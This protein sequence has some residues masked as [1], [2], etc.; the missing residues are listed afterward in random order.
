[1]AKPGL[2]LTNS[3]GMPKMV[4]G[5]ERRKQAVVLRI[6][7]ATYQQIG[8]RI[9]VNKQRAYQ[10]V[11][12]ALG[13]TKRLT[14]ESAEELKGIELERLDAL[15]TAMWP[16]AMKGDEQKVDR[17]L[18]IMKRRAELLGLDA[19]IRQEITTVEPAKFIEVERDDEPESGDGAAEVSSGPAP[20]VG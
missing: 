15:C 11:K 14:A 10:L 16:D 2:P 4:R 18:R 19:P 7:G 17:V 8:D 13:E 3:P 1:M 5:A 9:G 12:Q 20:S 6:A